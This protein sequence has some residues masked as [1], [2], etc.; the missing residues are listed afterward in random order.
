MRKNFLFLFLT[1]THIVSFAADKPE[2]IR[3]LQSPRPEDVPY[4]KITNAPGTHIAPRGKIYIDN[5]EEQLVT[6]EY[7]S[8]GAFYEDIYKSIVNGEPYYRIKYKGPSNFKYKDDKWV[9]VFNERSIDGKSNDRYRLDI[10][11]GK[12]MYLMNTDFPEWNATK[13]KE[14]FERGQTISIPKGI[15]PLFKK[16]YEGQNRYFILDDAGKVKWTNNPDYQ[17]GT[18]P[19]LH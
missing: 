2:S 6:L 3:D 12:L 19:R 7:T 14:S 4:Y 18:S 13:P 8:E 9:P 17:K 15:F 16:K 1:M 5:K 10:P 11:E